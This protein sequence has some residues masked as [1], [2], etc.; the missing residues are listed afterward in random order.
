M[1]RYIRENVVRAR[2][3]RGEAMAMSVRARDADLKEARLVIVTG[4]SGAGRTEAMRALEDLGYF[5]IDNLPPR[6]L[7][8]IVELSIAANNRITHVAAACDVRSREFFPELLEVLKKLKEEKLPYRLVFLEASDD[9]LVRRF[10]RERRTHPLSHG[11]D[12]ISGIRLEREAT[13]E[14]KGL[15][16]LVIDTSQLEVIDLKE[17]LRREFLSAGRKHALTVSIV[18]F[19]YKYGVPLDSDL[20][21]DVRFI[22]NPYYVDELRPLTG[23]DEQV[24]NYVLSQKSTGKFLKLTENLLDYVLPLYEREGKTHLNIAIGCTGGRHRSVVIADEL[25]KFFLR[26]E[27]TVKVT[28]RDVQKDS[29]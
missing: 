27:F 2:W 14:L 3:E 24:R 19:G 12:L 15:A 29:S 16:D 17:V 10:K 13:R 22:P 11:G 28:L 8:N 5:C 23:R 25:E 18:A 20:V 26:R 7:L 6:F 1:C 4:M 21:F 9:V